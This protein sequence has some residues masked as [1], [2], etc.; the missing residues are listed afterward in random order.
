MLLLGAGRMRLCS[1]EPIRLHSY[2]TVHVLLTMH[3]V[4]PCCC[5]ALPCPE[6][7]RCALFRLTRTSSSCWA[8]ASD[9]CGSC[10]EQ[11][12]EPSREEDDSAHAH[13]ASCSSYLSLFVVAVLLIYKF[14]SLTNATALS[15]DPAAHSLA[16]PSESHPTVKSRSRRNSPEQSR[17]SFR[18]FSPSWGTQVITFQVREMRMNDLNSCKLVI[19]ITRV[20]CL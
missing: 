8:R 10:P 7:F 4:T 3:L 14:K 11:S 13:E 9:Y 18:T 6:L 12:S 2:G 16:C 15:L 5:P 1:L 20:T 19:T 17:L